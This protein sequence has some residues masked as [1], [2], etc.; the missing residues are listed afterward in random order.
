M[1]CL[2]PNPPEAYLEYVYGKQWKT[3]ID[4]DN[5]DDWDDYYT[6]K[7]FN[8]TRLTSYFITIRIILKRIAK[9]MS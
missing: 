8:F 6:I 7:S 5:N 4:S 1:R 3:P 9:Y 2:I